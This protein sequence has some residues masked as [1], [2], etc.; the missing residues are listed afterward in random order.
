[1]TISCRL[2]PYWIY[3]CNIVRKYQCFL[4]L[5][6]HWN[7]PLQSVLNFFIFLCVFRMFSIF[8][9][10]LFFFLSSLWSLYLAS[11]FLQV[12]PIYNLIHELNLRHK[13]WFLCQVNI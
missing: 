10:F 2:V 5:T 11:K 4:S 7:P 13:Y 8:Y 1:L 6:L 3:M 9:F 12:Y